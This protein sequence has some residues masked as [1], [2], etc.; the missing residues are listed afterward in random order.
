[1]S[2]ITS[3]YN[4]QYRVIILDAWGLGLNVANAR[5]EVAELERRERGEL[6][7]WAVDCGRGEGGEDRGGVVVV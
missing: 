5:E 7:E 3:K 1:M 4:A 2:N 6:E